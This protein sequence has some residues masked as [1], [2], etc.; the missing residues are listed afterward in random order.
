MIRLSFIVP[1]YNVEPYIEECIR[2]LYDQ[3]IPKLE[4]EV[5][6]VDD[7]SPD[8]SRAIVESL[9]KEYST[10]YLLTT[11]ENL[12]QGGARNLG[13]YNARGK[14]VWFVDSDDTIAPNCLGPML[15]I[16]EKEDLDF[17]RIYSGESSSPSFQMIEFGPCTGSQL[18]FDAPMHLKPLQ[19]CSGVC[20]GIIKRELLVRNNIWFEEKVQF[21]DDDYTYMYYAMANRACLIPLYAYHV[22]YRSDST[23]HRAYN[24]QTIE[25]LVR[26]VIRMVIKEQLLHTIDERWTDL[27]KEAIV[28][29]CAAQILANLRNMSKDDQRAFFASKMGKI[30]GLKNLVP[31]RIWYAMQYAWVFKYFYNK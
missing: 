28:W 25:Y 16:A 8:G 7:C 24:M 9:Q 22:R 21:E 2:S 31:R 1:F 26:Q 13:L 15:N 12:R 17:L 11:P 19:R 3:D 6:C 30:D 27:I 18:V 5:I 29:T 20:S 10:L 14:Y 23:T 4:Y